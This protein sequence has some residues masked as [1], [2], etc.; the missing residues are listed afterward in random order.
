MAKPG[1]QLRGTIHDKVVR[2]ECGYGE[3][4]DFLAKPRKG[5]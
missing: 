4:K 2:N 1:S 5:H 3:K